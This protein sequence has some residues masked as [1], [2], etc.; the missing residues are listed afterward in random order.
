MAITLCFPENY[1]LD[2]LWLKSL[3]CNLKK[4]TAIS[5][6]NRNFTFKIQITRNEN[7]DNHAIFIALAGDRDQSKNRLTKF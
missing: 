4:I 3:M 7:Q 2:H 6:L 5:N 1:C